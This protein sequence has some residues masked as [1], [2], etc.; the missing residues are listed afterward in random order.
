MKKKQNPSPLAGMFIN[1]HEKGDIEETGKCV[2]CDMRH[3]VMFIQMGEDSGGATVCPEHAVER[4]EKNDDAIY[5]AGFDY[6]VP[7]N[8]VRMIRDIKDPESAK[9]AYVLMGN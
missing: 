7:D 5:D 8:V 3:P 4:I 2:I 1:F 9:I 6:A